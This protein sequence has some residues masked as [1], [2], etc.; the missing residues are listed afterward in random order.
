MLRPPSSAYDDHANI[1][2]AGVSLAHAAI[3]VR[4]GSLIDRALEEDDSC[5]V[6]SSD[7][8]TK[9]AE[10]QYFYPDISVVCDKQTGTMLTN[11]VVVIEVLSSATEKRDRDAKFKAYQALPSV[12]EYVLVGSEYKAIEVHRREG[13]FLRNF[14]RQYHYREGDIVEIKSLGVGIPFDEVYRRILE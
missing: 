5:M 3:C 7:V 2:I 9:L 8:R 13:S 6:Y 12:Q 11:P 10:R 4:I 1:D 14:L